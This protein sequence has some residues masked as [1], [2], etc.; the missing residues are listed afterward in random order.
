M[1][2][3]FERFGVSCHCMEPGGCL[4]ECYFTISTIVKIAKTFQ[5][6]EKIKVSFLL[7]ERIS[8]LLPSKWNVVLAQI[9]FSGQLASWNS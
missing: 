5:I 4:L 8:D 1:Q 7:L 3:G 9:Y 6:S 2:F